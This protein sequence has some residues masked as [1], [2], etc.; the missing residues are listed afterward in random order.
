M[1]S[2]HYPWATI[3][4]FLQSL[5]VFARFISYCGELG[6]R[7]S[8]LYIEPVPFYFPDSEVWVITFGACSWC[9]DYAYLTKK[10]TNFWIFLLS[11]ENT[12][13]ENRLLRVAR[14]EAIARWPGHAQSGVLMSG[15]GQTMAVRSRN[16]PNFTWSLVCTN[17]V[18]F[19]PENS[20]VPIRT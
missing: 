18:D 1:N 9:Q 20:D 7:D 5:N 15:Y 17:L 19:R 8:V 10:K 16:D 3:R 4:S 11:Q 6:S 14:S 2:L 13:G 12:L